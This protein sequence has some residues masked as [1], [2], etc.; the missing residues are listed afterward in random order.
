MQLAC[1]NN[2][3]ADLLGEIAWIAA[4]GFPVIDLTLEAP[5]AALERTDWRAVRRALDDSGLGVVCH[6]AP[7][8]PIGN[9]SPLVRQAAL[10]E[11]RRSLDAAQLLGAT[12]CGMH[13][14]GWPRHLSDGEGYEF[15]RQMLTI[16]V[17]HGDDRGVA[18]ALENSPRNE[19]QL[20]Y[21]R[22][23]F[24][25]VPGLRLLLD[26]AHV[27]IKTARSL[28]RDYLF[29]LADRLAHVHMSDNDGTSDGHLPLGA[30]PRGGIHPLQDLRDLRTFRYDGTI[31]LQVFGDRRLL[32]D[33]AR[34]VRELW[35]T[36]G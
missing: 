9:P 19:H 36:A 15:Y 29:A 2:P 20:K 11:L 21:F 31:T 13:F 7:Y 34:L 6:S 12:V 10:D 14:D 24:Q 3:N 22:E 35:E 27:N 16:L 17:R 28:T 33:S 23:I 18:L 4:N 8:L 25:R 5:G 26:V 32:L 1:M 30:P